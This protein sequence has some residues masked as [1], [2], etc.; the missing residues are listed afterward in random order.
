MKT[1]SVVV[2]DLDFVSVAVSPLK[3]DSPLF[4]DPHAVLSRS[5]TEEF[6]ESVARWN[7]KIVER[8]RGVEHRELTR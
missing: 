7:P 3:P 4:V 8:L 5:A 1:S 6:L 2:H